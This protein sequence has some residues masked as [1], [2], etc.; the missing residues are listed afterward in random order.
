MSKV[1]LI[2]F[3]LSV[4]VPVWL[5]AQTTRVRGK[6]SDAY[7]GEAVP[8]ATVVFNGTM[9]GAYTDS[10]GHYSIEIEGKKASYELTAL[11]V[12]YHAQS[13]SVPG[14]VDKEVNF[15]LVPD[16]RAF[17]EKEDL[18][19]LSISTRTYDSYMATI[20]TIHHI[21]RHGKRLED[22]H[23]LLIDI[24]LAGVRITYHR[25]I[26]VIQRQLHIRIRYNLAES[27]A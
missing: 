6:V 13:I 8:Y 12:G 11:L 23:L 10:T 25:E 1:R 20:T 2:A 5:S 21:T 19:L 16:G 18:R 17:G 15:A 9:T 7:S 27:I 26:L 3:C 24:I 14:G 4:L 22:I